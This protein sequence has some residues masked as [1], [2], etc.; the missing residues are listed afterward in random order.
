MR[1]VD[2]APREKEERIEQICGQ[3]GRGQFEQFT[4]NTSIVAK[5]CVQHK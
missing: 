2:A 5:M 4:L 1:C 3:S